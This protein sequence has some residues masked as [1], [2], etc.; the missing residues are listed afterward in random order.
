MLL[1]DEDFLRAAEALRLHNF[2]TIDPIAGSPHHLDGLDHYA[3]QYAY[4]PE[5]TERLGTDIT[6][7]LFPAIL[8]G[9][10]L[11]YI[12]VMDINDKGNFTTSL[13]IQKIPIPVDSDIEHSFIQLSRSSSTQE[14][15][16]L[17]SDDDSSVSTVRAETDDGY[18]VIEPYAQAEV[19]PVPM[20]TPMER[21][22][23]DPVAEASVCDIVDM[24]PEPGTGA[25]E[26]LPGR[27]MLEMTDGQLNM[28]I[29][30]VYVPRL[31]ALKE[32]FDG[33]IEYMKN[34][35]MDGSMFAN[36]LAGWVNL[37]AYV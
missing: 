27:K 34:D 22:N 20:S 19:V 33:A 4:P 36:V 7:A 15:Q 26:M 14:T 8:V 6:V 28:V 23:G 31:A 32:S 25:V 18:V 5:I 3:A 29:K 35:S 24:R 10:K 1:P 30:G 37:L 13:A 12:P 9:W 21:G 11:V 2:V 17:T 16:S